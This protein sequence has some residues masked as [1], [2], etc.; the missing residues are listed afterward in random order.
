MAR[1]AL[2]EEIAIKWGPG[3]AATA[4]VVI[5]NAKW[6]RRH[7]APKRSGEGI[8]VDLHDVACRQSGPCCWAR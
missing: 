6:L 4:L 7:G 8:H 2:F 1:E 3:Q 5:D